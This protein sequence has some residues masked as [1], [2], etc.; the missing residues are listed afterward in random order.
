MMKES[1]RVYI[2]V[3]GDVC[4]LQYF[5]HLRD[6]INSCTEGKYKLNLSIKKKNPFAFVKANAYKAIDTDSNNRPLPFFHIQDI[7]DY[8]D[9]GLKKQFKALIDDMKKAEDEFKIS[10]KLGYS[11]YTFEL[12]MLLHVTEMTSPVSNRRLYL[13]HINKFFGRKYNGLDEYKEKDEFCDIL[14][15]YVTLGSIFKAIDRAKKICDLKQ[16]P[17]RRCELY[18]KVKIYPDNP[19]TTVHEVV[20]K[21]LDTCG[22][23]RP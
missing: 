14:Q 4:E 19:Y 23:H 16:Y 1:K 6:L 22:I 12:W 9:E 7:E 18:K 5:E 10:T 15:K 11:N 20:S 17:D 3:E 2:S 21:I 8:S 13:S